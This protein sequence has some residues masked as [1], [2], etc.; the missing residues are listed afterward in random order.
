MS[1]HLYA[2]LEP[3]IVALI[4]LVA[5]LAVVRK[6]APGLW[7][8]LGGK[9]AAGG[10]GHGDHHDNAAT[11]SSGCGSCGSSD[12]PAKPREHAIHVHKM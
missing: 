5:G 12:S 2:L 11:C 6:H 1:H 9:G 3:A 10:C 8:R 7:T 4:V